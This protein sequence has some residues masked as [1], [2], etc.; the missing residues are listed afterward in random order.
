MAR[1][2][3]IER[4]GESTEYTNT[5]DLASAL[6]TL[7]S[8]DYRRFGDEVKELRELE[9]GQTLEPV[10]G[11]KVSVEDDDAQGSVS[12]QDEEPKPQDQNPMRTLTADKPEAKAAEMKQ[13]SQ[14]SEQAGPQKK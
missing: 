12:T 11:V 9:P 2:Y 1:V 6:R 10:E 7:G 3:K 8:D 13:V 14:Q 4:E 5:T